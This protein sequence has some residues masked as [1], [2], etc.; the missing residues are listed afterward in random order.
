LARQGCAVQPEK[1]AVRTHETNSVCRPWKL[2]GPPLFDCRE[3][4]SFYLE[5]R[6]CFVDVD[7]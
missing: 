4:G 6:G 1:F 7:V 5:R 3:I 2:I